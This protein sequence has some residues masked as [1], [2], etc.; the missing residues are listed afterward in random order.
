M[1]KHAVRYALGLLILLILLC[2]VTRIV[3]IPFINSLDGLIYDAKLRLTMPKN[4][5][6]RIVILDIDEKSLAEVG[7][8][9]WGRDRMATLVNKLFERY[10][11]RLLG[12]DVVLAEPDE[13]SG[14]K[15]LENLGQRE[16]KNNSQYLAT[17]K[18]IAPQLSYDKLFAKSLQGR[19]VI[20]GYFLS[21]EGDPSGAIPSPALP[22]STFEGRIIPFSTWSS[23]VGNLPEFQQAAAGGGHLSPIIDSD[24]SV[25]RVP[26][27]TRYKDAYYEAFS[28]GMVRALLDNPKI[29]PGFGEESSASE[30][31]Y[32]AIEWLDLPAARGTM[33]IP[34]DGNVAALVPYRGYEK[35][36]RYYSIADVLADRIKPEQLQG[37]IVIVGTTAPGLRDQRTTPVGEVYAGVEVHAN[38]ISGMLDGTI[39][40]KPQYVNAVEMLFLIAIGGF[41]IFLFPW[42]SPLR[43]TLATLVV[44]TAVVAINMAFWQ[45]ANGVLPLAASL[46]LVSGLFVLGMSYGYFVESRSKKQFTELFGQYVPPELVEEMSRNPEGYSMAG[47]KA[48]LTVLFSD[49]RGFTTIS[50]SMEPDQL[51]QLMNEY[52]SAMTLVVRK[53]RG[54]LDK[55][56]GDAIMAFWGAPV[57]EP[58]HARRAVET[59]L[60]MQQALLDLNRTLAAKGAP[61]MK[62]GIGINTG[63]MTVGDMGSVV[64]RAYTVMG[65]AVN[66]GSRL[67]SITKQ[68]GV[69]IIVG[70]AT[71][72]AVKDMV[73][74]EL[75]RV[76]VKGKQEPTAIFEPL[77]AEELLSAETLDELK[78]WNQMLYYYRAQD[79]DHA[80]AALLNLL[81]RQPDCRLYALYMERIAE[82]RKNPPSPDWTGVTKFETK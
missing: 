73:F 32:A 9:P 20:L 45:Y 11:V 27:L 70:E 56:I 69:G 39:K 10:G 42:R 76:Q 12:F 8:W 71:R 31:N 67:E 54:T 55:Y 41:M 58:A 40:L 66:L 65:D 63:S 37:K 80:E 62:I 81:R 43:A 51:A 82:L 48:E 28:L 34:V 79:W 25:R 77:G 68:Y 5:D 46:L 33:R 29:V 22:D 2:H 35:S 17:I 18:Q 38:L 14:L 23:H 6:E 21:N 74:R 64:R 3:E 24:G 52:L 57:D 19:P 60:G 53:H 1:K 75:D 50:E 49:V 72:H 16:L 36:Y 30:A 59:A 47:R 13:S 44:L 15:V 26:L 7:R 61:E 78:S 4:I